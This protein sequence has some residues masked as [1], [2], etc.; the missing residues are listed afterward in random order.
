MGMDFWPGAVRAVP[1][2]AWSPWIGADL[3]DLSKFLVT[4]VLVQGLITLAIGAGLIE[5]PHYPFFYNSSI[6]NI[7]CRTRVI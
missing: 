5:P 3:S 7:A 1:F 4:S 6:V 2:E